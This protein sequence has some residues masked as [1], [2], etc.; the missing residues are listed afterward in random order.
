MHVCSLLL[1]VLRTS[2][3]T[4]YK[5]DIAF[6]SDYVI[7]LVYRFYLSSH[8]NNSVKYLDKKCVYTYYHIWTK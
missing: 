8:R 1:F 7:F 5:L 2:C 6:L 3:A 4:C